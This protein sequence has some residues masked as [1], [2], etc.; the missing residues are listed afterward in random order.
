MQLWRNWEALVHSTD[1][2]ALVHSTGGEFC[3]KV[4]VG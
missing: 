4:E 3:Q 1:W 2:E